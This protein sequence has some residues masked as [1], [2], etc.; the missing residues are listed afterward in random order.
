MCLFIL[1]TKYIEHTEQES[2]MYKLLLLKRTI[3]SREAKPTTFKK[4]VKRCRRRKHVLDPL[5]EDLA[6][7]RRVVLQDF[8]H[9]LKESR[10]ARTTILAAALL[11][12]ELQQDFFK[13]VDVK[14]FT[15]A[16]LFPSPRPSVHVH[17]CQ[18]IDVVV[19]IVVVVVV[20]VDDADDVY[21]CVDCDAGKCQKAER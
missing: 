18:V 14:K 20:R 10:E 4:R 21:H 11:L 19:V 17:A 2:F 7:T 1:S 8:L 6:E 9:P 12:L 15:E 5:A 13:T 3:L 16:P